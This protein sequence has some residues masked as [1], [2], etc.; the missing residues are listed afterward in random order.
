MPK[1][2]GG[3]GVFC[4]GRLYL[5]RVVFCSNAQNN[6]GKSGKIIVDDLWC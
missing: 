3:G 1:G 2:G 4:R 5:K 6:F